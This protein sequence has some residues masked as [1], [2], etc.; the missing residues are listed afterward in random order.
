ME[1]VAGQRPT[2]IQQSQSSPSVQSMSVHSHYTSTPAVPHPGPYRSYP[3]PGAASCDTSNLSNRH[4]HAAYYTSPYYP[5]PS[6][7]LKINSA[8]RASMVSQTRAPPIQHAL[9]NPTI[10]TLNRGM[11]PNTNANLVAPFSYFKLDQIPT[12]VDSLVFH[13]DKIILTDYFY[14]LMMQFRPCKFMESDRMAKGRKRDNI[15]VGFAGVQCRH[16]VGRMDGRKFF[17]SNVDRLANSFTE[18]PGHLLKCR[19]C[20]SDVRD[21]VVEL[22][23]KHLEQMARLPRGSQKVFFR[24][25]WRRLHDNDN[26]IGT[27]NT[28]FTSSSASLI[29]N[30]SL[31]NKKGPDNEQEN[32]KD[33]RILLSVPGDRDWLSDL[34]CFVRRNLEVFI[35]TEADVKSLATNRKCRIVEGQVG[36]RCLHCARYHSSNKNGTSLTNVDNVSTAQN[37]LP[38]V[39]APAVFFPHTV[40]DI[41]E[42]VREFQK[43]HLNVELCSSSHSSGDITSICN[44]GS[45]PSVPHLCPHMPSHVQFELKGLSKTVSSLNSM[46]KRYSVLAANA[47]GLYDTRSGIRAMH[48]SILNNAQVPLDLLADITIAS[49]SGPNK[50]PRL[51]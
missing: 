42:F 27:I 1:E 49:S 20:P 11:A 38:G 29:P 39:Q 44:R 35:A 31:S 3:L 13:E 7:Y 23:K 19:K 15:P 46:L 50:K 51:S 14:Y 33:K 32:D 37:M 12:P 4:H 18:I 9:Y 17:W 25:M 24:R 41:F 43:Q 2:M 21:I 30:S 26:T 28:S 6:E 47:L 40:S 34:D 22:K 36:M 5:S 8:V 10:H 48:D 16:C 45:L